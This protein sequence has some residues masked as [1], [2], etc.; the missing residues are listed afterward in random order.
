MAQPVSLPTLDQLKQAL[1]IAEKIQR[2][3]TDLATVIRSSTPTAPG[4]RGRPSSNGP[5]DVTAFLAAA[6]RAVATVTAA[7]K[8]KRGRKPA[9]EA[10]KRG[11]GR[12]PGRPPGNKTKVK[13]KAAGGKRNMSEEGRRRIIEAQKKRWAA[14]AAAKK[15]GA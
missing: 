11:R 4:R 7:P 10:S 5:V 6:T 8:G 12:G 15:A 14:V 13:A 9:E 2:L 1:V 3:Q